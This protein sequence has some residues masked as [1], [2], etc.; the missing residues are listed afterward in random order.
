VRRDR[1]LRVVGTEG[2]AG[3]AA[4]RFFLGVFFATL[5][6]FVPLSAKT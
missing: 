6:A 2:S 1:A 4:R 5:E 3:I